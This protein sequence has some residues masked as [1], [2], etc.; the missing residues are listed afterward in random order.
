MLNPFRPEPAVIK[1][2]KKETH[3]TT[4]YT[5]TF[6]DANIQADYFF[7]PGQFNM[8]TIF[9]IGEAPISI[10]SDPDN[11]SSFQHTVR[12]VGNVTNKL[13]TLQEGAIVG[14]RGPY[15]TG[16]PIDLMQGKNVLIVAG[17][18]GLAPLRPVILHLIKH[19][20]EFGKVEI[21]YGARTPNDML[22]T[23]QYADWSRQDRF[24][25]LFTVDRITGDRQWPH[26]VG[27]VTT[28][29]QEMESTPENTLVLTCG[30]EIMMQFVVKNLLQRGFNQQQIYVSL[31]RRMNCGVRKC[32]KCQ[33]G[34]KF[35]C[36]DGPVFALAELA[37]LPEE[38]LGGVAIE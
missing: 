9:G 5:L 24:R 13:A 27:V 37:A 19:R 1:E 23:D 28:L 7:Q 2:I 6:K 14:V 35:V 33:I 25:V 11:R 8:I 29:F 18:I 31:E 20:A 38:T 15:G 22:Y 12:H 4:T 36:R 21:L 30:P 3:D 32:G 26:R 17:G 16:W 34:P 10:S